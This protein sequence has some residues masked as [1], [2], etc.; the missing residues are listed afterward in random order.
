MSDSIQAKSAARRSTWKWVVLAAALAAFATWLIRHRLGEAGFRWDQ[1]AASFA[2]LDARWILTACAGVVLSY[3]GRAL[4]WRVMIEPLHP[5]YSVNEL[6]KATAI[7]FMAVFLLGRPGELVR[8]YLI[9]NKAQVPLSSQLAAWFVERLWDLLAVLLI[10]GYTLYKLAYRAAALGPGLRWTLSTGAYV[11]AALGAVCLVLLVMLARFS[12]VMRRRLVDALAFLP[13]AHHDRAS[14][15]VAAFL[16]GAEAVKTRKSVLLIAAYTVLEWVIICSGYVCLFRA[17]PETAA[18]S[19]TDAL[20]FVGFVAFGSLV[21]IPG[22]GGGVQLVAVVALTEVFG[23]TLELATGMAVMM[24]FI[25]FA[26]VVPLG[27][28]LAFREGLNWHRLKELER[29]AGAATGG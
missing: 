27:L 21:Q 7:G 28:A 3:Y 8:P 9:A 18:L 22:L 25:S 16:E 14:R 15:F 29:E 12:G 13:P 23:Q 17:Y 24:W 11:L 10:F 4:R 5:G 6:F 20:A 26:A 1:F 19:W 2:R